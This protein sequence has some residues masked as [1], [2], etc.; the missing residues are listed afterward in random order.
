MANSSTT[1]RT[2]ICRSRASRP[3][4]QLRIPSS[5][6]AIVGRALRDASSKGRVGS[7]NSATHFATVKY[8]RAE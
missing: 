1:H 5:V 7:L 3:L 4:Q 8:D 6:S 2:E